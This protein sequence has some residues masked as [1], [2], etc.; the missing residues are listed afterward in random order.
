MKGENKILDI[1]VLEDNDYYR[2]ALLKELKNTVK[3]L[4]LEKNVEWHGYNDT[5][6]FIKDFKNNKFSEK[7]TLAFIDFYLGNGVNG[8]H[9][10][11]MFQEA[12]SGI[13]AIMLSQSKNILQVFRKKT[14]SSGNIEYLV[15]DEYALMICSLFL[16]QHIESKYF[17]HTEI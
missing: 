11:K 4:S 5:T 10:Y 8:G 17:L 14:G 9:I 15:K 7:N 1:V 16:E 12:N 6:K 2:S 3:K 13:K